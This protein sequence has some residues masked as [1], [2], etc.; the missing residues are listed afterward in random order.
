MELT[1]TNALRGLSLGVLMVVALGSLFAVGSTAMIAQAAQRYPACLTSQIEVTAGATIT[2]VSYDYP[3]GKRTVHAFSKKAAPVFFYN[4]GPVCHLL[5]G[6]PAISAVRNA[7]STTTVIASD[8]SIAVGPLPTT[9]RVVL[10]R[11]QRA[12]ALFLFGGPMPP[13]VRGCHPATATGLLVQGYADPVPS[14]GMF[15]PRPITNVCFPASGSVGANVVNTG[16]AWA[17]ASTP[18]SGGVRA[19]FVLLWIL[20]AIGVFGVL[21]APARYLARR[22][23]SRERSDEDSTTNSPIPYDVARHVAERLQWVTFTLRTDRW[24]NLHW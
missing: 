9:K 2:N 1:T 12:E 4:R 16:V 20:L 3:A 11:H 24:G 22:K 14:V 17:T 23:A 15:F 19:L 6:G 13:G 8:L 18:R 10:D 21:L 7:T 5:M